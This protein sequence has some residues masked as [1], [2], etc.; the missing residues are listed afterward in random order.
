[1]YVKP[2]VENED[3]SPYDRAH[4]VFLGSRFRYIDGISSVSPCPKVDSYCLPRYVAPTAHSDVVY[5]YASADLTRSS[6]TD[7]AWMLYAARVE[8]RSKFDNN[9]SLPV[10]SMD[11]QQ[12]INEAEEVARILRQNVVQ[13]QKVEGT[14]VGDKRYRT[15]DLYTETLVR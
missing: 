7:D 11:T 1:M 13:G 10:E 8:A 12:K 9:R 5:D 4:P 2:C 6:V 15:Y 14:G 3:Q